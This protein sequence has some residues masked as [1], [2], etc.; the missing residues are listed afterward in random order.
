ML[1]Q[2]ISTLEQARRDTLITHAEGVEF[3][4]VATAFRV[5]RP[6][7]IPI[8]HWREALHAVALGPR[9]Y[10]AGT[11]SFVRGMFRQLDAVF[12]VDVDP[13]LPWRL[14]AVDGVGTF[15][16]KHVRRW[17][18]V[19][20]SEVYR[21]E[22]PADVDATGAGEWLELTQIGTSYW[23]G[24]ALSPGQHSV[25]ILAWYIE[26]PTPGPYLLPNPGWTTFDG[27]PALVRIVVWDE[28]E[29]APPPTYLQENAEERPL[30]Q[31]Y[32]GHLQPDPI[33]AGDPLGQGPHPPYLIGDVVSGQL[34]DS[35]DAL[36][37]AGVRAE[38]VRRKMIGI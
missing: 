2:P 37:A 27:E 24:D 16:Q 22:G 35:L 28:V 19:D 5:P 10:P 6:D 31:P 29:S 26:E 15:E 8:S 34:Q 38:I 3:D 13:G 7:G 21:I 33:P 20:E 17:C 32:G 23:S 1:L 11:F 30:G 4:K 14:Y 9:G 25:A 18:I 36:L 12:T